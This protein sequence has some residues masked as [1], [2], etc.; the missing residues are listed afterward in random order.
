LCLFTNVFYAS[1]VNARS[2]NRIAV[3]EK[4]SYIDAENAA[5]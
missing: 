5:N 2:K 1:A 4:C 3:T